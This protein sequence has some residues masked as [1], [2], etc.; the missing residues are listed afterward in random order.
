MLA[1]VME[2]MV[3]VMKTVTVVEMIL[4]MEITMGQ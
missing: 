2:I 1:Y 4:M 3:T